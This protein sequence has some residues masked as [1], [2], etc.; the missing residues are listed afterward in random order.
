MSF[1]LTD[2][3]EQ[4]WVVVWHHKQVHSLQV[5]AGFQV[6]KGLPQ[7]TTPATTAVHKRLVNRKIC[8]VK[9]MSAMYK[10]SQLFLVT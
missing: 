8:L 1:I 10:L 5:S 9:M 2:K 6:A 3:G 4:D 7:L